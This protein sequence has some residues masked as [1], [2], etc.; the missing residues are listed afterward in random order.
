VADVDAGADRGHVAQALGD[1]Q[2]PV[3][4]VVMHDQAADPAG[5]AVG[6]RLHRRPARLLQQVHPPVEVQIGRC[7]EEGENPRTHS[8]SPGL[9]V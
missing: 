9:P 4:L 7:G 2:E 6:E 3:V 1:L 8:S 5:E